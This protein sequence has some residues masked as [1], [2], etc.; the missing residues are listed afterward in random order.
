MGSNIHYG[1]SKVIQKK[2]LTDK[3]FEILRQVLQDYLIAQRSL[4]LVLDLL[5]IPE[6]SFPTLQLNFETKEIIY[7]DGKSESSSHN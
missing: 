6:I 1:G 7:D 5:E 4:K 2:R 3:Q